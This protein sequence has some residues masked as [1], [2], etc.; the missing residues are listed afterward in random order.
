MK[1][2]K[3]SLVVLTLII[4]NNFA[5]AE[6][7]VKPIKLV[8][9]YRAGG[10]MDR[11][12][13]LTTQYLSQELNQSFIV[14]NMPGSKGSLGLQYLQRAKPDGYT[15]SMFNN[16]GG[17]KGPFNISEVKPIAMIAKQ[18]FGAFVRKS[19]DIK[20]ISDLKQR[21]K[22]KNIL[23]TAISS[24]GKTAA[25]KLSSTLK[26]NMKL[27]RYN[28]RSAIPALL[29]GHIDLLIGPISYITELRSAGTIVALTSFT[30]KAFSDIPSA[31]SLG[32]PILAS[33][34]YGIVVPKNTPREVVLK[35]DRAIQEVTKSEQYKK[36]LKRNTGLDAEYTKG[37]EYK[38]STKT[39]QND[40]C[41]TCDCENDEECKE[42][43]EEECEDQ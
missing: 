39:A 6:F 21:F 18:P 30:E 11:L 4:F 34:D 19:S 9:P 42:D 5:L 43:C 29:G 32:I 15:I 36:Q 1:F 20:D 37:S 14:I 17:N 16:L 24:V 8:V 13:R 23:V 33:I 35:L 38:T 41:E 22:N 31:T 3:L 25:R 40:F 27:I 2:S 10:Q 28:G 26:L 7:P 12:A